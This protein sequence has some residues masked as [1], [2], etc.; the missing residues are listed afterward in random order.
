VEDLADKLAKKEGSTPDQ[1][2]ALNHVDKGF[3]N[4]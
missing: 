3:E 1:K 2:G 4:P